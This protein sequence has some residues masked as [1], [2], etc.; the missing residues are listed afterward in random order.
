MVVV[1]L[2]GGS[3]QKTSEQAEN[4]NRNRV[5]EDHSNNRSSG[6]S[7][8]SVRV[9]LVKW[10]TFAPRNKFS[11]GSRVTHRVVWLLC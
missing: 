11:G 6:L 4:C 7:Q 5:E 2:V 1:V 9:S 8:V 10:K 3:G